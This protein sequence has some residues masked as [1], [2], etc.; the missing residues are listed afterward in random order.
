MREK[1]SR[2]HEKPPEASDMAIQEEAPHYLFTA[3]FPRGSLDIFS[4][5][6]DC[7]YTNNAVRQ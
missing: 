5:A 6:M 3:G 2:L 7:G 4:W 1:P